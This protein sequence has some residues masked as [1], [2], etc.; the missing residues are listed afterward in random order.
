MVGRWNH[1]APRRDLSEQRLLPVRCS[2][3][4]AAAKT[5]VGP[6]HRKM[7][8]IQNGCANLAGVLA[9]AL[10]RFLVDR[11]GNFLAPLAITAAVL[12]AGGLS[13]GFVVGPVEPVSWE[14][15]LGEAPIAAASF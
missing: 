8:G 15:K 1:N 3:A 7:D 6:R 4:G 10:T 14:S 2:A 13:W 9:Q 11:T 5:L 12:V